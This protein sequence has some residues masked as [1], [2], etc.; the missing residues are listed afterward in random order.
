MSYLNQNIKHLRKQKAY[1][2]TD[3]AERLGLTRSIIGAYEEQR[4][5]PKI[6]T[7][8]KLAYLFDLSLDQLINQDLSK[9][10][11]AK[12]V[13]KEGKTLR[14]LPIV[15]DQ[16]DQEQISVVPVSARAGYTHGYS[17]PDYIRE[18]PKFNL[19]LPEL[20][21][22]QS[23]RLFQIEGDSML[24]IPDGSYVI[25]EYVENWY[26]IKQG[27]SHI[28]I[29]QSQGLIYKRVWQESEDTLLLKSDNVLYEPYT[30]PVDELV[31]VW[32]SMAYI[33]FSL[34]DQQDRKES[35][36]QQLSQLVMQLKADVDTLKKK[37]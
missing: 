1:T 27:E 2:Q 20:Y 12:Q 21:T 17:D 22:G 29:T 13:D 16:E 26:N 31:E 34:P 35:D 14:I 33:S 10:V 3:L 32:R 8:Q 36:I 24:P 18:L 37:N 15:I 6:E 30:L 7:I 11:K 25:C 9:G 5:E 19:P 23:Y 4:A 28:L